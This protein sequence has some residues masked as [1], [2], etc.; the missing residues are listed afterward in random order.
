[1]E[2]EFVILLLGLFVV[3]VF[4]SSVGHGGAS[5]YLAIM[6]MTTYGVMESEWLKHNV[7]VL[8]LVVAGLAFTY[9]RKKGFHDFGLTLPFIVASI[10]MA[11]LGGYISIGDHYYDI[12]LSF[13]L[14]WASWRLWTISNIST[15]RIDK[16]TFK[17]ALP[18]GAGIGF[19][20]GIIG[21]GGGIFLSPLLLLKG[22]A[23][24]K[25]AAA[26]SA[27]FIWVN[28]FSGLVGASVSGH[29][30]IDWGL[31]PYFLSVVLVGGFIGSIYGAGVANQV[32]I[33]K[34]LVVLLLFAAMKRIIELLN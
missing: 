31:L 32:T 17:Q 8:N 3:A 23:T 11:F 5:G 33:K 7:W 6:S 25:G 30:M 19:I 21:V 27:L 28:S 12:L 26:T 13:V 34:I 24:P 18:W 15:K 1:M 9:Y 16:L 14:I 20:S 29:L 22:W 4:Y 10:P 2:F